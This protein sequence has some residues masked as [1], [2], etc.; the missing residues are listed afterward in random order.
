MKHEHAKHAK[1]PVHH[2]LLFKIR[3]HCNIMNNTCGIRK[4]AAIISNVSI[5][6]S[7]YY[8]TQDP[9]ESNGH[10]RGF[11]YTLQVARDPGSVEPTF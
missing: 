10:P 6:F 11:W 9:L 1:Q 4:V 2:W 5:L 3:E 8:T 7:I